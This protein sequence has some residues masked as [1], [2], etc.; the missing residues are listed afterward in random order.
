MA[1]LWY[2]EPEKDDKGEPF[3]VTQA[4]LRNK[5]ERE[6][7]EK[8][9]KEAILQKQFEDQ[10]NSRKKAEPWAVSSMGFESS[11][12]FGTCFKYI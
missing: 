7:E 2:D 8:R 3:D 1:T 11:K 10:R 12:S 9:K 4:K 5:T 6:K